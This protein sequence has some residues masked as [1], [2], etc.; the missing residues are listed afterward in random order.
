MAF[1]LVPAQTKTAAW[2]WRYSQPLIKFLTKLL[3]KY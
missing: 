3:T 1:R 2:D